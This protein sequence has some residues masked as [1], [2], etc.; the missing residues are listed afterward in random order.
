M[1]IKKQATPK[2]PK[3]PTIS[4]LKIRRKEVNSRNSSWSYREFAE[5]LLNKGLYPE[6]ALEFAKR[7]TLDSTSSSY[8]MTLGQAYLANEQYEEALK[9]LERS[10]SSSTNSNLER[11][12]SLAARA[13]WQKSEGQG[14]FC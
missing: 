7:A 3:P 2:K 11:P 9:A 1:R 4:V 10:L 14:R 12:T 5:Q 13:S 6:T 8:I